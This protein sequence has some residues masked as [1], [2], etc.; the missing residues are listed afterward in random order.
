M[1]CRRIRPCR[2]VRVI[3]PPPPPRPVP[4]GGCS[5]GDFADAKRRSCLFTQRSRAGRQ[6][7]WVEFAGGA[8]NTYGTSRHSAP[9]DHVIEQ[10]DGGRSIA[11]TN[12]LE[13]L[14]IQSPY[15]LHTISMRSCIRFASYLPG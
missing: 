3:V 1:P 6:G 12:N 14:F 10:H 4:G 7:A 5:R 13:Y 9:D 8:K 15:N 2:E 11:H